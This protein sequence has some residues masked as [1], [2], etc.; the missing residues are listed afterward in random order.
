MKAN[1]TPMPSDRYGYM[2][3]AL[4]VTKAATIEMEYD[5]DAEAFVT[6]PVSVHRN[7]RRWTKPP[8]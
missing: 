7:P 1:R 3:H 2:V 4:A 5:A 6:F 8:R